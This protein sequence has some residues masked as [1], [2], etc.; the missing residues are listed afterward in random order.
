MSEDLPIY[1]EPMLRTRLQFADLERLKGL[2]T[3]PVWEKSDKYIEQLEGASNLRQARGVVQELTKAG[4]LEMH[5]VLFSSREG[6]GRL[7]VTA[8]QPQ[9]RG[10]DC[11]EPQFIS[12]SLDSF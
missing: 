10:H 5:A 4:L 3:A 12:H 11:P 8:V 7:R 2:D 6:A 9:Y 1:S